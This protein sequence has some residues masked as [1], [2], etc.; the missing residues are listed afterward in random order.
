MPKINF[1]DV[2]IETID[3]LDIALRLERRKYDRF[4]IQRDLVVDYEYYQG[5]G[6]VVV[7]Y[8]L[9]EKALKL[10]LY[11]TRGNDDTTHTLHEDLYRKLPD[12]EKALLCAYYDDLRGVLAFEKQMAF[13]YET[14]P[15]FLSE[16]DGVKDQ[17]RYVGSFDWRYYLIEHPKGQTLPTVSIEFLH[18]V[19]YGCLRVTES[20]SDEVP[21]ED[22]SRMTYSWRRNQMRMQKYRD[23]LE[24]RMNS[25]G[26]RD[27]A[28]RLEVLWGE[29]YQGRSDFFV[30]R[31]GGAQ[32]YFDQI[33]TDVA[34]VFGADLRVVDKRDEIRDYD[35][36]AGYR[37]IGRYRI[38]PPEQ[39]TMLDF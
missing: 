33:P 4:P 28:D 36:E 31:K 22:P 30:F 2:G 11:Q 19:I 26:W 3:G 10:L 13:P 39:M 29:D 24:V 1:K 32:P 9:L 35:A 7:A 20:N 23:W 37:K 18:E 17:G 27:K 34:A 12:V 5:W 14:L 38:N 15:D 6:Y 21:H 16:L 25:D 8:F